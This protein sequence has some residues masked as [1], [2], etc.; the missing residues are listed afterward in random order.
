[1][2]SVGANG[3]WYF[4]WIHT[5]CGYPQRHIGVELYFPKPDNLPFN[6]EWVANTAGDMSGVESGVADLVFSGQNIEHLWEHDVTNF[7]METN[8]ILRTGGLLVVDSP[9][10]T[11]TE[12]LCIVH[13][14]HMV[15]FT[16]D[17]MVEILSAAGFDVVNNRGIYLT[18][19]PAGGQFL[20]YQPDFLWEGP[21]SL[22][23]R[24]AIAD[25]NVN[26]SYIW[27]IEARKTNRAPDEAKVR[28]L[29]RFCWEN[30]WPERMNRFNSELSE[31]KSDAEKPYYSSTKGPQGAL[32]YGP[33]A[34]I[35]RGNYRA[36]MRIS[37]LD[38]VDPEQMI[39]YMDVL[40]SEQVIARIDVFGRDVPLREDVGL[41]I[42]FS[43]SLD[44]SF[45]FQCRMISNGTSGLRIERDL[46]LETIG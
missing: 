46:R 11:I 8:R 3:L 9:N 14:E 22:V 18:R 44:T 10:R 39:G 40:L 5:N 17:E 2:V 45:G 38:P 35:T 34:P 37:R 43:T 21:W 28:Q 31:I 30:G 36:S 16:P 33:Y 12:A 32:I 26:D 15:E 6:T 19:D 29:I 23:E 42:D 20:P 25:R 13:P 24:C 4:D 7:L 1:M 27:W 41:S